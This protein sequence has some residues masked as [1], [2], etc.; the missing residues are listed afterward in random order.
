MRN[1]ALSFKV[2]SQKLTTCTALLKKQLLFV[3][4]VGQNSNPQNL[5]ICLTTLNHDLR[6]NSLTMC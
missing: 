4:F 5:G 1:D 2:Y 3:N 6:G